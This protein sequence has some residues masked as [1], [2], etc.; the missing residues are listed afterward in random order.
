MTFKKKNTKGYLVPTTNFTTR[1]TDVHLAIWLDRSSKEVLS[2]KEN[3]KRTAS[4]CS[5]QD[6]KTQGTVIWQKIWCIILFLFHIH[7][8]IQILYIL[9]ANGQICARRSLHSPT[10]ADGRKALCHFLSASLAN[11]PLLSQYLQQ[12]KINWTNISLTW[13]T[14]TLKQ[15]FKILCPVS[16][17]QG[18]TCG[19]IVH[20]RNIQACKTCSKSSFPD[21]T[22]ARDE[23][24]IVNRVHSYMWG[25]HRRFQQTCDTNLT[26]NI[27]TV[28]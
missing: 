19:F 20:V 5:L 6:W 8:S 10:A 21:S 12:Q 28:V 2:V 3:R 1:P 7:N 25:H 24:L 16:V 27:L 13:F 15:L 26:I 22:L 11:T 9:G 4:T 18:P 17:E 23:D 14:F